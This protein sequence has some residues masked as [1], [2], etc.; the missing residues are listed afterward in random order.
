[1]PDFFPFKW[2]FSQ[3]PQLFKGQRAQRLDLL[4]HEPNPGAQPLP[5]VFGHQKPQRAAS[6]AQPARASHVGSA[7]SS[8]QTGPQQELKGDPAV[9][10]FREYAEG[11]LKGAG[12]C[13]SVWFTKYLKTTS[14]GPSFRA[15]P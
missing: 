5:L 6:G 4:N 11:T 3:L 1:M 2:V 14:L 8:E 9:L 15:P 10:S 7:L 13:G 12:L